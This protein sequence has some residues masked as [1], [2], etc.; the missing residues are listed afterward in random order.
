MKVWDLRLRRGVGV[1]ATGLLLAGSAHAG[2]LYLNELS[3]T[4]QA[5]A[6]AGR[7][8]WVP[9]ASATLH[10]PAAM[11]RLDDHG[12]AGGLSAV[13]GNVKFDPDPGSPSGTASGGNQAKF[14]PLASFSYAHRLSDRVRLGLSFYSNAGSALDPDNDWAGRFEMRKLSLFTVSL[15][16]T[17]AIRVTDWLSI[18]GG[19]IA[20]Y[21]V[22]NWDLKAEVPPA[23]GNEVNVQLDDLDDWQASGRVGLLL[24]PREDLALS[25]YYNSETEFDLQGGVKGPAG[26]DPNLDSELPMA[27]FVEVSGYWQATDRLALLATFNWED[28]SSANDL[29][30]RLATRTIDATTGFNDTYKIGLGANY[31]LTDRWL[32]QTGIM[33]DTSAFKNKDRT[34]AIPVDEQIRFSLGAQ[35]DLNESVALGLSFT[36]VHLGDS[37][38]RDPTVRGDYKNNDAFVL[39]ATLAFKRLP[40]SGKLGLGGAGS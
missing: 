23:S 3:T 18:G 1:W 15:S 20:S 30:I 13:I 29:R 36:Y 40:W 6:G 16:P 19:P 7:G 11:T 9:D 33:Y 2:G 14:A 21:A 27:Q 38:V 8:A 10:N 17:A 12:L 4:S 32:L 24:H 25:V 35:H 5:N 26:L 39:G 22:L 28:W 37:E 34:T 31:R